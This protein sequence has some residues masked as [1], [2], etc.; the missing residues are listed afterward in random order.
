MGTQLTP[1]MAHGAQLPP[2]EAQ[3][4]IFGP[5]PLWPNGFMDQ[6]ATL[7]GSR[8]RPRRLCIRWRPR[9]P[10]QNKWT[11]P[12]FFGPCLLWSIGWMDQDATWHGV[13]LGPGHTGTQLPIWFYFF[14]HLLILSL[15]TF[16]SHWCTVTLKYHSLIQPFA[17]C[18]SSFYL[19][20]TLSYYSI[21]L[22]SCSEKLFVLKTEEAT[23]GSRLFCIKVN[24][25]YR[26]QIATLEF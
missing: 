20:F 1:K 25:N 14:I 21:T 2:K 13:G 7:Y 22:S 15:S 16:S 18:T 6:D 3:P 5:C 8:P 4:P 23:T 24:L 19:V 10:T 17:I 9:S 12:Q 26:R 11:Q